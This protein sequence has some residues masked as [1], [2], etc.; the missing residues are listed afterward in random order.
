MNRTPEPL[1]PL[2]LDREIICSD[3]PNAPDAYTDEERL[4]LINAELSHGFERLR[5]IGAA[6]CVFGSARTRPGDAEYELAQALGRKLG[7]LGLTVVT[8]GGPGTMEA[9]N[10][11]AQIG[12]GLSVG[13]NIELPQ[14]QELNPY[15]DIGI[16][17]RYFFVRKLMLVRYVQAFIIFPGG[18]GTLDE[19]FEVLT[20]IQTG[21]GSRYPVVL[22]GSEYWRGLIEWLDDQLLPGGR[23]S[24]EDRKLFT[25]SDDLPG[26]IDAVSTGLRGIELMPGNGAAPS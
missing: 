6:V 21:K 11:G 19:A 5:G 4:E 18:Y 26:I 25:I 2:I 8:G 10:R 14:E 24:P 1:P 23:I 9:A 15:V 7:E 17:F 22:V 13:L 16:E 12:G 20:L 3:E